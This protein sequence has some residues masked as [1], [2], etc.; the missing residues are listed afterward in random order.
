VNPV[1]YIGKVEVSVYMGN[2]VPSGIEA[3]NL[4]GPKAKHP[5]TDDKSACKIFVQFDRIG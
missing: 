3:K 5:K 2:D 1:A 4:W